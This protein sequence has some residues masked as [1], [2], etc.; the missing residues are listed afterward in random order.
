MLE[1][2]FKPL[3]LHSSTEVA[4]FAGSEKWCN[5]GARIY[6]MLLLPDPTSDAFLI[7]VQSFLSSFRPVIA[8]FCFAKSQR[9]DRSDMVSDKFWASSNSAHYFRRNFWAL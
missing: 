7:A 2:H 4:T 8:P 1:P 3:L 6:N 5:F 9:Y